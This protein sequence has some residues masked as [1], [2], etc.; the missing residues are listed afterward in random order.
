[1]LYTAALRDE[2]SVVVLVRCVA[3]CQRCF[4]QAVFLP[5]PFERHSRTCRILELVN[6]GLYAWSLDSC[7]RASF[8]CAAFLRARCQESLRTVRSQASKTA[9]AQLAKFARHLP[10]LPG[11]RRRHV[12]IHVA[13]LNHITHRI[14]AEFAA[15]EWKAVERVDLS[16]RD[17]CMNTY[18]RACV[19]YLHIR[20]RICIYVYVHRHIITP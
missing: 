11:P 8:P 9:A 17:G 12:C 13:T 5:H 19:C 16:G 6:C 20:A 18:A 3:T 1:M 14:G 10:G 4:E 7:G 15:V 2:A